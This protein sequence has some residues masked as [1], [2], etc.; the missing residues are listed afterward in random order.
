MRN[1]LTCQA[2]RAHYSKLLYSKW[3]S[4]ELCFRARILSKFADDTKPEGAVGPTKGGE[5]LERDLDKLEGNH[6]LHEV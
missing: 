4:P 1:T 6:Q 5:S 2:Q 3:G